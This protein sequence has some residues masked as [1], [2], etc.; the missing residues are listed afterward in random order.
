M[1][2]DQQS[3]DNDDIGRSLA[4]DGWVGVSFFLYSLSGNRFR[5]RILGIFCALFALMNLFIFLRE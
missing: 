2:A 3:A 5:R 4:D 1:A